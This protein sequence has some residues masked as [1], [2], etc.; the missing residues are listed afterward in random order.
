M[1]D[2]IQNKRTNQSYLRQIQ[3]EKSQRKRDI[4]QAQK[5]DMKAVRDFYAQQSKQLDSE[6]AA[7]IN[8]IKQ[9]S[10]QIAAEERAERTEKIAME[11]AEKR[12]E[13]EQRSGARTAS[14]DRAESKSTYTRA[15][16]RSPT[17]QNY[18]TKE[19]DDFYRVQDRGSRVT[20]NPQAYIIE[21][22]APE[23]EKDDLRVSIQRN[24]AVVSGQRKF[25]DEAEDGNKKMSTNNYQSFREEFAFD[26]PV[27]Q[28]GMTRERV[29]DYI[30]FSIPKM[31][32]VDNS[33]EV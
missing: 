3:Q 24:K 15:A 8:H 32:A 22:Y 10:R 20:E 14:K 13:R 21:A 26:R 33:D 25:A 6:S 27:S 1:A 30:R 17:V 19:T 12:A 11:Q 18:Q 29:G 23:H 28:A 16:K 5:E 4:M 31:E 9:E 2:S 7:A